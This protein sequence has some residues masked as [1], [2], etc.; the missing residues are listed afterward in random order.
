MAVYFKV[1]E[2][3]SETN[4]IILK[5]IHYLKGGETVNHS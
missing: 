4:I 5:I 1:M 2:K 3:S